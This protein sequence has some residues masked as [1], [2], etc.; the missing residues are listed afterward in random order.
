MS[1]RYLL[2]VSDSRA[3]LPL[4]T[5]LYLS[6]SVIVLVAFSF[7]YTQSA[8][9]LAVVAGAMVLWK[10][11]QSPLLSILGFIFID[12]LIIFF[13]RA[14]GVE[15]VPTAMDLG[16]GIVLA[17]IV[18]YWL[19]RIRIIEWQP[20]STSPLQVSLM[21]FFAWSV[22]VTAGGIVVENNP[23]AAGLREIL[24][25][26]PLLIIPVL[27]ERYIVPGS[28]D[29]NWIFGSVLVSGIVLAIWNILYVRSNLAQ[30]YYLYQ[31]G[32]GYFDVLLEPFLIVIL[33]S[34]LMLEKRPLQSVAAITMVLLEL[35]AL[36]L[37]MTRTMYAA[38]P[39][40]VLLIWF[41]ARRDERKRVLSRVIWI[42]FLASVG[43]FLAV[44]SSHLILMVAKATWSRIASAQ[45]MGHDA[46][47]LEK[48]S[49]WT[50]ETHAITRSPI[51]GHG[52][53][54]YFRFFST[55]VHYHIYQNFSH[56]SYLYT[57]FKTG[58][59]GAVLFFIPFFG[60]LYKSFRLARKGEVP[61]RSR[62]LLLGCFGCLIIALFSA[63]VGPVLFD[64]KTDLMWIGLIWGYLLAVEKQLQSSTSLQI[65]LE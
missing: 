46:S 35:L 20:L 31:M 64:S 11:I 10:V 33:L 28:K 7:I 62:I 43:V 8:I 26:I 29:E 22:L 61:T 5:Q 45:L 12:V 42:G 16:I 53:G 47:M 17:L 21:L 49:E 40:A 25:F 38:T 52:F 19:F 44:I 24:N 14:R 36:I 57:I 1:T 18:G 9:G 30:V 58:F 6:C 59:V 60:S 48:F 34:Y 13:P 2:D 4:K 32:R 51:L 65:K 41:L 63:Y 37:S 27:Y 56:N 54:A 39:F 15:G 3:V 55:I 23:P 50:A